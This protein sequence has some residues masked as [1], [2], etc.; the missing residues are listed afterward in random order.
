[1]GMIIG[2]PW[3]VS[4]EQAR[5]QELD[6]RSD[7]FSLAI[8]LFEVLTGTLPFDAVSPNEVLFKVVSDP[9]PSLLSRVPSLP[10][11][12]DP[13]FNRALAKNPTERFATVRELAQ[14]VR[15][16]LVGAVPRGAATGLTPASIPVPQP[17]GPGPGAQEVGSPTARSAPCPRRHPLRGLAPA[18][19]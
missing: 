7:Q 2:T 16:V 3:Y 6:A 15:A 19:Q 5:G 12:L 1:M 13:L 17:L 4:P 14:Q 8:V 9:T 18:A 11:E 10:P